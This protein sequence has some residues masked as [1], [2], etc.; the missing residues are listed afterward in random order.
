MVRTVFRRGERSN[1]FRMSHVQQPTRL[2]AGA[3]PHGPT[4]EG[5]ERKPRRG[6]PTTRGEAPTFQRATL[7]VQQHVFPHAEVDFGEVGHAEAFEDVQDLGAMALVVLDE[8]E[9]RAAE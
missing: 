7:G 6:A 3:G 5:G 8:H 2:A 9:D 4:G 1:H